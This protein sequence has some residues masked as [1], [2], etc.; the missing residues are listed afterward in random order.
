MERGAVFE[1]RTPTGERLATYAT[2]KDAYL[3]A[4]RMRNY[5][6]LEVWRND[7][8][9]IAVFPGLETQ[10]QCKRQLDNWVLL[11]AARDEELARHGLFIS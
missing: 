1:V 9:A 2:H 8:Y 11:H 5:A 7:A 3:A 10:L 4:R 6:A